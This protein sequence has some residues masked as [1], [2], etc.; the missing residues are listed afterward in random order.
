MVDGIVPVRRRTWAEISISNVI[1]NY[2]MLKSKLSAQTKVC[3]VVKANAYGHGAVELSREYEKLGADFLAVSNIE[4]ALALREG[5]IGLPILILGYTDPRCAELLKNNNI[6]QCVFSMEYASAL[7]HYAKSA[8]VKV[9]VHI[10]LDTGMGRLGFLCENQML[11]DIVKINHMDFLS[12]EGIFT[13]FASADEGKEGEEYTRLQAIKFKD[14]IE[15]LEKKGVLFKIKHCANSATAIDY[16]EMQMDMVRLGIV[17]YGCQ[18]DKITRKIDLRPVMSLKTV[19]SYIKWL[20]ENFSL[21]YGREYFTKTRTRVATIPIGYADGL[22][23]SNYRNNLKVVAGSHSVPIIGR[24]CMDQCMLDIT[25]C[26][27]VQIGDEV[28]VFGLQKGHTVEDIAKINSTI[29]YEILCDVG[30]RVPR[31]Y[32]K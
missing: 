29:S 22:W 21:S 28:T 30:A 31:I 18:S 19:I 11:D 2:K 25:G 32:I 16:P 5:G 23:R 10:K 6:Q 4:E 24:V 9:D 13:H 26:D 15:Y 17:L 20:P 14:A 8:G 7:N 1:Y 27:D 12:I 3:C